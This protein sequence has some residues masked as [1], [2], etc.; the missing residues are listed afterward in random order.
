MSRCHCLGWASSSKKE[1]RGMRACLATPLAIV[2]RSAR[3]LP[4]LPYLDHALWQSLLPL[5]VESVAFRSYISFSLRRHYLAC[6]RIALGCPRVLPLSVFFQV[7]RKSPK[8]VGRFTRAKKKASRSLGTRGFARA[9]TSSCAS[10]ISNLQ[11]ARGGP[12]RRRNCRHGPPQTH[13]ILAYLQARF[14]SQRRSAL[15]ILRF[16]SS[17]NITFSVS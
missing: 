15:V 2:T 9:A 7:Y 3:L 13:S 16:A 4:L 8:R 14:G 5:A 10:R 17:P 11:R 1:R 12:S 6:S